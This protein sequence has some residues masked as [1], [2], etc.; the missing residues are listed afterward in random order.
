MDTAEKKGRWRSFVTCERLLQRGDRKAV[1]GS[2]G[3][4]GGG[5]KREEGRDSYMVDGT[6]VKMNSRLRVPTRKSRKKR[7]REVASIP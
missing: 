3:G 5:K 2:V 4:L 7:K 6:K 1:Y